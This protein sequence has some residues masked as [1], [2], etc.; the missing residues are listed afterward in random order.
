MSSD[1]L[2]AVSLSD[3]SEFGIVLPSHCDSLERFSPRD[4]KNFD[5]RRALVDDISDLA[6]QV[7]CEQMAAEGAV[8]SELGDFLG[9]SEFSKINFFRRMKRMHECSGYLKFGKYHN[10]VTGD[11]KVRLKEARFC[12]VRECPMCQWRRSL[13]W[14]LRFFKNINKIEEKFDGHKFLHLTLTVPNCHIR[15][16]RETLGVMREAWVKYT[17]LT[18]KGCVFPEFETFSGWVRSVE[19]TRER[20][21]MDF[22]HP[23]YHVLLMVPPSYFGESY[24]TQPRFLEAWRAATSDE[25]ISQVF[26]QRVYPKNRL[27]DLKGVS[28]KGLDVGIYSA[29][30]EVV[31]YGTKSDDFLFTNGS[32]HDVNFYKTYVE[33]V[34]HL[35]FIAT[36][37]GLKDILKG[38]DKKKHDEDVSSEEMIGRR[39]KDI[40]EIEMM[41]QFF[42]WNILKR[43]Y[44]RPYW[45]K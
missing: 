13:V 17:D 26:V 6:N 40:D 8:F 38:E 3:S 44:L 25:S 27:K 42:F 4:A 30:P 9:N 5:R 7:A 32:Q 1:Y 22:V 11:I 35:R 36:G 29:I 23:H 33:Q 34:H 43:K 28:K 10:T 15:K 45:R 20:K 21:R 12:R 31:K 19:V 39:E 24:I 16:L 18:K 41:E 14:Y 2:D 37:T